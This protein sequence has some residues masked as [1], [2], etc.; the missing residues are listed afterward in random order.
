MTIYVKNVI[1]SY[2]HLLVSILITDQLFDLFKLNSLCTKH[3]NYYINLSRYPFKRDIHI[4]T[5]TIFINSS[6]SASFI[7]IRRFLE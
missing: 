5:I 4:Y 2:L 7:I 1:L 3:N 6:I